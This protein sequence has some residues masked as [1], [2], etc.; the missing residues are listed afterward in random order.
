M[1]EAL[2]EVPLAT[3]RPYLRWHLLR[4]SAPF[5]HASVLDE[6]FRFYGATLRGQQRL[7][8]REIRAIEQ[9]NYRL[10]EP[11]GRL[12]SARSQGTHAG[13]GR[14]ATRGAAPAHRALAVAGRG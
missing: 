10:G 9:I 7:R 5:L 3:W 4:Q 2:S 13:A 1:S 11:R 14:T 6:N 12:F 8:P